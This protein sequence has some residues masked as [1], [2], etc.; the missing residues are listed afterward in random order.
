MTSEMQEII[1]G[2]AK[3]TLEKSVFYNPV[4]EFNRDI[5]IACITQY[6]KTLNKDIH[7]F[8]GLSATG[9]R[10]IR[11]AKEIPNVSKITTNDLDKDAFKT[12]Q[13]NVVKN[14]V[15]DIITPSLNDANVAMLQNKNMFD[16]IDLDPYGS[17]IPFVDAA[18]QSIKN[19][20]LLCVT[21]TDMT[22]LGGSYLETSYA[23]YGGTTLKGKFCHEMALRLV[24]HALESSATRY[25]R[26]I[27]P[28]MSCSIDFYVRVFVI[29][30]ESPKDT[31]LSCTKTSMVGLCSGCHYYRLQPLGVV[32]EN[33][34]KF[35]NSRCV[36]PSK[37]TF[38]DFPL[39]IGG[40]IY[41]A[42]IHN[43]E[44][45][46]N[47]LD[48]LKDESSAQRFK[49]HKR[50]LGMVSVISEELNQ[51]LYYDL[52]QLS[53]TIKV[54]TIPV[55]LF[56]SAL[57]N[58]GYKVS[59][60]HCSKTGFKTDA[61]MDLIWY[62]LKS[63]A[64][65]QPNYDIKKFEEQKSSPGKNIMNF[66]FIYDSEVNFEKHELA[67][68]SSRIKGLTRYQMNPTK[69]WGPGAK[70]TKKLKKDE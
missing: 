60:T 22:V 14:N 53:S 21:C 40:P 62:V 32:N 20:G 11:Y 8:E 34:T 58:E 49:T 67:N 24:L 41:S 36:L 28:L 42:D 65:K 52:S 38:C 27:V 46:V 13:E 37:C 10:S 51:P 29:V 30:K 7:I 68:P 6:Q 59:S 55:M 2:Q 5:S 70:P 44:F 18:I 17:V 45:V 4:Q 23:K 33:R 26:V 56:N 16:V 69:N 47:L 64:L 35:S 43:Q 9:L 54:S 39:H 61:P 3:M 31:K 48:A 25:K 12:I 66:N 19:G 50:M 63:W 1:E 57:L 15:Q